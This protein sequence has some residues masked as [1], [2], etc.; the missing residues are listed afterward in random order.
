MKQNIKSLCSVL[1]SDNVHKINSVSAGSWTL[2]WLE[3]LIQ[4]SLKFATRQ[5]CRVSHD[6]LQDHWMV[7]YWDQ[8]FFNLARSDQKFNWMIF[9]IHWLN[10]FIW[11][12]W[13]RWLT[14]LKIWLLA[15]GLCV[16]PPAT[17]ML[18]CWQQWEEEKN[19]NKSKE[20]FDID[21]ETDQSLS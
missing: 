10:A 17:P 4:P 18:C 21:R 16:Q 14:P 1:V 9:S 2:A 19:W 15:I 5:G 3:S 6:V 20:T 8:T 7:W 11:S 12:G 13:P